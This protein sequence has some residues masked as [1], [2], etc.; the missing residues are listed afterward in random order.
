MGL[1]FNTFLLD[2]EFAGG[3]PAIVQGDF[4]HGLPHDLMDAA[5]SMVCIRTGVR[6]PRSAF[7]LSEYGPVLREVYRPEPKENTWPQSL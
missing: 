2:G 6:G 5:Q 1:G 4:Q 7:V 3:A